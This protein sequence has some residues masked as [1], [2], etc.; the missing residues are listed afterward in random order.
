MASKRFGRRSKY[1][2]LGILWI[3]SHLGNYWMSLSLRNMALTSQGFVRLPWEHTSQSLSTVTGKCSIISMPKFQKGLLISCRSLLL[4]HGQSHELQGSIV[5]AG[6]MQKHALTGLSG[7]GQTACTLSRF[8][9]V[10]METG[11]VLPSK[12]TVRT[13]WINTVKCWQQGLAT[14]VK[15]F[16]FLLR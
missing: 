2:W 9:S 12:R 4:Q 3:S 13:E 15:S 16:V 5:R 10:W 6:S 7:P 8:L 1:A 14:L 11:A